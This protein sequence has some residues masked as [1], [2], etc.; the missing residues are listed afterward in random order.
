MPGEARP[1]AAAR[2]TQTSPVSNERG[3]P[4]GPAQPLKKHTWVYTGTAAVTAMPVTLNGRPPSVTRSPTLT[5]SASAKARSRTTPPL[6]RSQDPWVTS[7]WS[8]AA[9]PGSRPSAITSA[10]VPCARS[11]GQATG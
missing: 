7:G 10:V 6:P 1:R 11:T 5:P 3:R 9:R 2:L 4:G 8:T